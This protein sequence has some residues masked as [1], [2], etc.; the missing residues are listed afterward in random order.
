MLKY[1]EAEFLEMSTS[2]FRSP[3]LDLELKIDEIHVWCASLDQPVSQ[4]H[5]LSYMLSLD[6]C[7][8]AERFHFKKDRKDFIIGRGILRAILGCYLSVEP[9]MLQFC[10]GKNGK[11]ALADKFGIGTICF[12]LSHSEGLALY[13]FTRNCEIGVDIEHIRDISEIDQIAKRFFSLR[14]NDVLRALPE[15]NKKET[16]FNCWTP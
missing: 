13:A 7:M 15:R 1:A 8:R 2:L 16:F 14:E 12:N 9:S 3:P 5:K 6:E 4:Y 10:Y 11:P